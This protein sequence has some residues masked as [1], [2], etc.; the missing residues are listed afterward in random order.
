MEKIVLTSARI[1]AVKNDGFVIVGNF[2]SRAEVEK[3]YHSAVKD[4][5]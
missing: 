2:C 1:E 4:Q 5:T 3:L